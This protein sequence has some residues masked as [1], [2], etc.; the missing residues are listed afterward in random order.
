MFGIRAPWP[1]PNGSA[2]KVENGNT[3]VSQI[4]ILPDDNLTIIVVIV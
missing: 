1:L 4:V 2:N 3:R